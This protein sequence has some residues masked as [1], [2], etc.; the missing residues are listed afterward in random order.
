M[1][2]GE[3][4]AL[5]RRDVVRNPDGRL[6]IQIRRAYVKGPNG[7]NDI[8]GEP[9]HGSRRDIALGWDVTRSMERHLQH[10]AETVPPREL[11]D[12]LVFTAEKGRRIRSQNFHQRAWPQVL[13]QLIVD[14]TLQVRPTVHDLRHTHCTHL[15]QEGRPVHVVQKRLGHKSPET[16]LGVYARLTQQD[17]MQA[18]DSLSW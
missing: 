10:M 12:R 2:F 8:L 5:R 11:P 15:L 3:A 16:T 4:T 14:G 6:V 13:D 1:R 17:D 7:H 18:A 9:T